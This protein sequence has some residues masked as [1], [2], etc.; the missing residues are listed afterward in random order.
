MIKRKAIN[1]LI[2]FFGAFSLAL[3]FF[4]FQ[5]ALA[6]T[7][8]G[9]ID[10]SYPYA[11][12]ENIGWLNLG[13]TEGDVHVT[14]SALS[15][16]AWG[17]NI[18][19]ISLNCSDGNSC[20]TVDYK[21][22]ND[23]GGTLSGYAWGENVGWINFNPT[24]GGVSIDSSGNFSGYAWGENTGWIIFNCSTTS[25]CATVDY[26]VRTDYRPGS[27]RSK[28]NNDIDDDGDGRTDYPA[29]NGCTSADDNDEGDG[30]GPGPASPGDG[31]GGLPPAFKVVI[32]NNDVYTNNRSIS[33]RL[34]FDATVQKI[35]ISNRTDFLNAVQ[36]LPVSV[37]GWDLCGRDLECPAGDYTIY[38][39]FYDQY[40]FILGTFSDSIKLDYAYAPVLPPAEAVAPSEEVSPGV[41]IAPPT[42]LPSGEQPFFPPLPEQIEKVLDLVPKFLSKL[43]PGFLKSKIEGLAPSEV[44][45]EKIVP[46]YTPLAMK[47][48]WDLFS[49]EPLRRFVF[50]PLPT[51]I[52]ALTQKF[53]ELGKTF[54]EVGITKVTDIQK[55]ENA[56]ITL[57]G[58]SEL[59]GLPTVEE[60]GQLT[61][62]QLGQMSGVEIKN[63]GLENFTLEQL[64][65][66]AGAE[67]SKLTLSELQKIIGVPA[68]NTGI[69][70]LTLARLE[71]GA[72]LPATAIEA[73]ELTL[74]RGIPLAQ[75][76]FQF[77]QKMPSEIIFAR[78]GGEIIDFNIALTINERGQAEQKIVTVAGRTLNLAVKPDGP[79]Q[80]VIGYL[81]F[82]SRAS[83]PTAFEGPVDSL[84][85]SWLFGQ[86]ALAQEEKEPVRVEEKLVLLEFEYTDPDND[87]IYTAEIQAPVVDGEYEIITVIDYIDPEVGRRQLR[88]LA[89]VDPEG[90]IYEGYGDKEIRVPGAIVSI[91]WLNPQTKAYELWPAKDYQ[92]ENP[93]VTDI[94]G[95]YSFLVPPGFY[96]TTVEANG[97]LKYEGKPFQVKE[98]RGVHFNIEIKPKYWWLKTLDWKTAALAVV[99]LFLLYNFYQDRKRDR[100]LRK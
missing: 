81:V 60:W 49:R 58:L 19:W 78:T 70:S 82:K 24:Y 33:L 45:L 50:A 1:F 86:P 21:V 7:T 22:A 9:T 36:E 97:Y 2:F 32:N 13:T 89:V 37:K 8:D 98:G 28:C 85:Y 68:T 95:K 44:P 38:V 6:S 87:G 16:Y 57:P 5:P 75:L 67:F 51:S 91:F 99:I 77:K 30:G 92:Q 25:S 31:G 71:Q 72:G 35:A 66:L 34:E 23:G 20:A 63:T 29:D 79:A 43:V 46:L 56:Q 53:P 52:R 14:D 3:I 47:G 84:I 11:W 26:S 94:T 18:G 96:Y 39:H 61:L 59:V 69:E 12:G 27:S 73:G 42:T 48:E 83:T 93:Q 4:V 15:G 88:L 40:G 80:K 41:E 65:A 55:L 76:P 54:A 62:V 90:Y 74:P 64:E 17:E 100:C 10:S